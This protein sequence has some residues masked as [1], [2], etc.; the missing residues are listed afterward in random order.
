MP[1][2]HSILRIRVLL[3]IVLAGFVLSRQGTRLLAQTPVNVA[4]RI[5][6]G[7]PTIGQITDSGPT[8]AWTLEV[9][10]RDR[11]SVVVQRTD[12]TLVPSVQIED[13]TDKVIAS[14]EHD[15]T[16]QS[17]TI[18]VIALPAAG[19]YRI[20][21]GRDS[22]AS[23][24][25]TGV[26]QLTLTLLGAGEDTPGLFDERGRFDMPAIGSE[27]LSGDGTITGERWVSTW[28]IRVVS[29]DY[30][31]L[32][33]QRTSDDLIPT[34]KLI[35]PDGKELQHSEA[36]ATG[37]TTRMEVIYPA[38]GDYLFEVQRKD[39]ADGLTTGNFRIRVTTLGLGA[40][41]EGFQVI[42]GVLQWDRPR[43]GQLTNRRW[44]DLW[45]IE[46]DR[47][48]TLSISAKRLDG[49]LI[50]EVALLDANRVELTR[51]R[52]DD[53]YASAT[54]SAFEITKPGRYYVAVTRRDQVTGA[55]TGRYELVA[56]H[57]ATSG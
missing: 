18:E 8:E 24:K 29:R 5:Q 41:N 10:G 19:Q 9:A 33:V 56:A 12:G 43:Q 14:A 55:T 34:M 54:V 57:T 45:V 7:Q 31:Q 49:S 35:G 16:A 39:G 36:D 2:F 50:P 25:T 44:Q 51:A 1:V 23:G 28:K 22:G 3:I 32:V 20:V 30:M 4:G 47:P 42:T 37:M 6:Y 27:F 13:A 38:P 21:V 26:Y 52:A 15:A 53:T 17:A 48:A 40:D 11:I 46:V